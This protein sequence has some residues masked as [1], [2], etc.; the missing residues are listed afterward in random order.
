MSTH[1]GDG[2]VD[3]IRPAAGSGDARR[4][5]LQ[6]IID[7][8][9]LFPPA[10][11]DMPSTVRNYATY[12]DHDD[13]WMLG[14]LIVPV[15]RLDEFE[16]HAADL[17]PK[18]DDDEPWL[19]SAL[20][21]P[22]DSDDLPSHL[23]RIDA[24]N[25]EHGEPGR[26]LALIDVIELKGDSV[27]AIDAALDELP[28]DLFPFFEL[29]LADDPRGLV[30]ALAG[31]EAGAKAR[32]GGV[33]PELY[34]TPEHLAR[35]ICTC[36]TGD[37]PFKATAGLHHP[38]RHRNETV[39]AME[40]GFLNVFLAAAFARMHGLDE[41]AVRAMLEIDAIDAFGF[42]PGGVRWG[43]LHLDAGAIDDIRTYFAVSFG[44][45]S[46]DEPREDLRALE[47]L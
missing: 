39:G 10:K 5:L 44:S 9:G 1:E 16:Q 4:A 38:L 20:T 17:L 30:A 18:G 15:A 8:A 24:F 32:T 35:F 37:V 6:E 36:V 23:E 34:P 14:R 45:C 28:D 29:P 13:A 11:L 2:A 25:A 43:D 26:G 12:L 31:G 42:E 33:T 19:I 40:F 3:E 21:A 7:Y 47:L 46:F 27:D 41:P 22:A